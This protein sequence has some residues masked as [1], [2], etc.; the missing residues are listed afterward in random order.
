MVDEADGNGSE[1]D[2][3][4]GDHGDVGGENRLIA[5]RRR[6]LDELRA[7]GNAFPNDFRRDE[8]AGAL[9]AAYGAHSAETLEA[10]AVEVAVAGRMLAQ[11]VQ[12]K[13]SFVRLQ[14]R[15]GSIQLFV[16]RDAVGE[17][18]Y[19]AFKR[20]DLGDILGA[21]GRLMKTRTGELSVAVDSLRLLV[22]ALRPLPEKWHGIAD[23][24]LKLR[25][26]YVDLIVNAETR[27]VFE[28]RSALL[29]LIRRYLDAL[30]F[31][32]VET[33]MMHLEHNNSRGLVERCSE[34]LAP[35]HLG[36][37]RSDGA[38][39]ESEGTGKEG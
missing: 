28:K 22:K 36:H 8:T 30:D 39:G 3:G 33:P 9:H 4:Q 14:D 31:V 11:R 6:K 13:S 17:E 1:D 19:A 12:G 16:R 23:Q 35:D 32:E 7:S 38:Q 20:W 21:R 5:E 10:E 27:A 37:D 15:S 24:E 29:R 25:R 18:A 34:L 2:G 26:R